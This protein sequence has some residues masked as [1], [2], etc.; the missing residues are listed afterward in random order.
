MR[1]QVVRQHRIA[2][3]PQSED[4]GE[5]TNTAIANLCN[6]AVALLLCVAQA[7]KIPSLIGK[8]KC[9][10]EKMRVHYKVQVSGFNLP[11]GAQGLKTAANTSMPKQEK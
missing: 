6:I 1:Y 9:V 5:I 4:N 3:R 2:S 8:K 11:Q 10:I 7:G